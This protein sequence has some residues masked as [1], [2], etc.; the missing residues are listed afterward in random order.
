MEPLV[1]WV[2]WNLS[3]FCLETVL[4]SVQIGAQF[5]QNVPSAHKSFRMHS[6]LLIVDEAQMKARSI[7][8]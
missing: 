6:M 2:M 1:T 5:A 3:S 7:R 4:V 8:K